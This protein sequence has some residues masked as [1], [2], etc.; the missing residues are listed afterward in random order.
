MRRSCRQRSASLPKPWLIETHCKRKTRSGLNAPAA[1]VLPISGQSNLGIIALRCRLA[2]QTAPG[3]PGALSSIFPRTAI[4]SWP[5]FLRPA[6]TYPLRKV[7]SQ[8]AITELQDGMNKRIS[9]LL[10]VLA[11]ATPAIAGSS[12]GSVSVGS[13]LPAS[14]MPGNSA[15]YT[16]TVVRAGSGNLDVYLTATNL[17]IGVTGAFVPSVVH[18]SGSPSTNTSMLT[19]TT[20]SGLAQ[21]TYGFTV[22]GRD[23]GSPN[24]KTG[25]GVLVVG[26]GSSGIQSQPPTLSV[27]K[28]PQGS[29][30]I[31]CTGSPGYTYQIQATTDVGNPSWVVIGTA[32][33]DQNGVCVFSDTDANLY[34]Q[35]FYRA[36]TTN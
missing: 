9:A 2:T 7:G 4:V 36:L 14:I 13:Q 23:G 15:T 26:S 29:T 31:T 16:I 11:C 32:T 34:S 24:F 1:F 28:L 19:L 21:G 35:R 30:Q 8:A 3:N 22:V 27:Q 10:A 17:P 12:V 18:F 25:D 6:R 20:P 5:D 33:S